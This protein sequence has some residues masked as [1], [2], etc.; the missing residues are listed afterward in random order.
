[1]SGSNPFL[2]KPADQFNCSF[3]KLS[4]AY[5]SDFVD[6]IAAILESLILEPLPTN[7]RREPLPSNLQLPEG[8]TFHKIAFKYSRGASGQIRII[9]L[10]DRSNLTIML[11]WIYT[12]E[13]FSGRPPD[14]DLK[15][16]IR[17][18]LDV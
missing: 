8:W 1:V 2:I 10:L 13:Q 17:E 15:S 4:K 7:S 16:L 9:Y 14:R 6:K 3:K 5:R 12:H 18:I 11:L